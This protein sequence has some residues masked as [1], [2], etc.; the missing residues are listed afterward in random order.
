MKWLQ[1]M[2]RTKLMAEII[3][4]PLIVN[5]ICISQCQSQQHTFC[6]TKEKSAEKNIFCLETV[7]KG[8]L[9]I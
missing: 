3:F 2:K 9:H 8:S 1:H 6:S 5:Q 7:V 4:P